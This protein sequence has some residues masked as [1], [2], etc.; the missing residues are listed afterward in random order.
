MTKREYR[1]IMHVISIIS[2]NA[3][4][5]A[6]VRSITQFQIQEASQIENSR[7]F[8]FCPSLVSI[9]VHPA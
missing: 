5:Q 4:Y 8:F 1:P 9:H 6:V 2:N 3:H 7:F